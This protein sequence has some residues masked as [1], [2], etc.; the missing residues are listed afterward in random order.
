MVFSVDVPRIEKGY[1][2]FEYYDAAGTLMSEPFDHHS[3]D[4]LH[5]SKGLNMNEHHSWRFVA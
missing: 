3:L 1:L 5:D 2:L 4:Q